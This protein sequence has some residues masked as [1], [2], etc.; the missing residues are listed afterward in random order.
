MPETSKQ[1]IVKVTNLMLSGLLGNCVKNVQIF[2]RYSCVS[3]TF[4]YLLHEL[5]GYKMIVSTY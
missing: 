2:T 3:F 5:L 1:D 4:L